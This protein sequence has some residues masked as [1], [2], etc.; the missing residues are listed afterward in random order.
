[1]AQA[2]KT[3]KVEP[4]QTRKTKEPAATTVDTVTPP[5][6]VQ[7]AVDLFRENQGQA[8]HFEGEATIYKDKILSFS[9]EEYC[10]RAFRGQKKSFKILGQESIVNFIIQD[11]S[12]G[13]TEDEYEEFEERW[14]KKAAED[15]IIKDY[16]SVR[17]DG[18]VLA[19]HYDEIVAALQR[20]PE[21]IVSRLFKPMLLKA[22]SQAVEK[23]K[24]YVRN[25]QEL[26]EIIKQLKIKH[27]IK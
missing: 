14:G 10:N 17:L 9:I 12:A 21:E 19:E 23:A 11:S 3:R 24:S 16:S 8:K 2:K 26:I 1:M 27:Y 25:P 6:D 22:N 5:Q 20:L 13:L 7:K 15:L 4:F 18:E